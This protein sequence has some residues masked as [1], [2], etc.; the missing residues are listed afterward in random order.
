MKKRKVNYLQDYTEKPYDRCLECD[1]LGKDCDGPNF[2]AMTLERWCEWCRERKDFLNW[3]NSYIAE[4]SGTSEPTVERIMAG[5]VGK[6]IKLSTASAISKVLVN[7]SWGQYPCAMAAMH[8]DNDTESEK[9][10]EY[11]AEITRLRDELTQTRLER[12]SAV[13]HVEE[14]Q[15]EKVDYFKNQLSETK[16]LL[17]KYRFLTFALFAVLFLLVLV[18]AML[19]NFGWFRY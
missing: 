7:G 9:L 3:T 17:N 15:Q 13:K 10:L 8:G 5:S 11:R 12:Q 19:P 4:R 1:H 2:E 6:D 14:V 16:T 18:V